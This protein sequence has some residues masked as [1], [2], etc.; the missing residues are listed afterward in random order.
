MSERLSKSQNKDA[1]FQFYLSN[2]AHTNEPNQFVVDE[3]QQVWIFNPEVAE[4]H[5][6]SQV[7]NEIVEVIKDLGPITLKHSE[8]EENLIKLKDL[9]VSALKEF[10]V[11]ELLEMIVNRIS[12]GE[13]LYL[14]QLEIDI[15]SKGEDLGFYELV[16]LLRSKRKRISLAG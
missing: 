13:S 12:F 4:N 7:A 2:I 14:N 16:K 10:K 5:H 9:I 8:R 1:L 3:D 6:L 11:R 15:T